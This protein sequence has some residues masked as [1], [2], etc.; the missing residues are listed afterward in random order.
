MAGAREL[1]CLVSLAS[2]GCA[3]FGV[4]QSPLLR[5]QL[6][7]S[8]QP[9]H[10]MMVYVCEGSSECCAHEPSE[11]IASDISGRFSVLLGAESRTQVSLCMANPRPCSL[12]SGSVASEREVLLACDVASSDRTPVCTQVEDP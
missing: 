9:V 7:E 1:A 3:G 5:V 4:H 12:W 2:W 11:M 8:G 6:L 10:G